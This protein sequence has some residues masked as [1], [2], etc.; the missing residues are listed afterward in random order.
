MKKQIKYKEVH[1]YLKKGIESE[2]FPTGCR[3]ASIRQLSLDF[4]CS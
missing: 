4:L 1:S 3:L 2:S